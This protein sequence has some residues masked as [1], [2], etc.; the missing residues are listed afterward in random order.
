MQRNLKRNEGFL[1][2]ETNQASR[3]DDIKVT[4]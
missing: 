2:T 3:L 4:L 1:D